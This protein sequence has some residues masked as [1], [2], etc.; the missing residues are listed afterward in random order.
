MADAFIA[1]AP[2]LFRRPDCRPPLLKAET[3][4]SADL[5]LAADVLI[6]IGDLRPLFATASRVLRP[7]GLFAVTAQT[8]SRGFQLGDDL[9]YAQ[10]PSY[11]R[12]VANAS[13][14]SL[15]LLEDAVARRGAGGDVPGFVAVL[16]K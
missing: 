5:L 3:P 8:A 12:E 15:R 10:A 6:Y 14:L 4:D 11:I 16:E 2:R 7:K 13:G 9:R 1:A